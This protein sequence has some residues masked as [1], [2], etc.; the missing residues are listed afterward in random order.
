MR[1]WYAGNGV[2]EWVKWNQKSKEKVKKSRKPNNNNF[3]SVFIDCSGIFIGSISSVVFASMRNRCEILSNVFVYNFMVSQDI[4]SN[5]CLMTLF[6]WLLRI[7]CVLFLL[8]ETERESVVLTLNPNLV[9]VE[10]IL[11][12]ESE[13]REEEGM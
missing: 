9:S 5:S 6:I 1:S 7:V 12:A 10:P 8:L 4:R 11:D 2:W 3:S 13:D